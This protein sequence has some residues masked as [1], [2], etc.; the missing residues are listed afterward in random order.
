MKLLVKGVNLIQL[1]KQSALDSAVGP[2]QRPS[3]VDLAEGQA[4]VLV[5]GFMGNL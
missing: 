2:V 5:V 3:L 1:A 4:P